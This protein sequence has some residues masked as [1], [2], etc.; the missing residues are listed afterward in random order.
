MHLRAANS[1]PST[2]FLSSS[3]VNENSVI[4]NVIGTLSTADADVYDS[5]TYSLVAGA[6]GGSNSSFTIAG[7]QLL[8]NIVFNY[9]FVSSCSIRVQTNG[10]NGG[11]FENI[12]VITV[13]N[14]ND[15][16]YSI[17]L[18]NSSVNEKSDAPS[19]KSVQVK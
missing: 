15:V 10:G 16:P 8:S 7:N 11:V 2:I 12:F 18:S 3:S 1:V 5:H 13:N 17:V 19:Q 9:E 4:G 6:G 14:M